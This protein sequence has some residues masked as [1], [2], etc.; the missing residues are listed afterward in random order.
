MILV[1]DNYDSF[2]YNL[3][4]YVED[5]GVPTEIHRNDALSVADVLRKKPRALYGHRD[6]ASVQASIRAPARGP[7]PSRSSIA[8]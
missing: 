4:H 7:L 6:R 8:R 3:V 5:F 2:V 1:I